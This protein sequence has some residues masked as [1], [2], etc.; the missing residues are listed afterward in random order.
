[1]VSVTVLFVGSSLLASL[2]RAEREI[3]ERYGVAAKIRAHNATLPFAGQQWTSVERDLAA[4]DIVFVI[5]VTDS[6]N[7]LQIAGALDRYRERHRAVVV[8]N[9]LRDLM[10][11]TRMGKLDLTGRSTAAAPGVVRR[12]GAWMASYARGRTKQHNG[13]SPERYLKY[14]AHVP[15]IL[16]II[17][18]RGRLLD[19]KHYLTLFSYFL[20]PTPA[21]VRSMLL[22]AIK[23]YAAV[24][25]RRIKLD[26]PET[27]PVVGIYH[28]D[29]PSVF[30]TFK[31]YRRWYESR[32]ARPRL[33]PN[34]SIGMLLMRTQIVSGACRHYDYLIRAIESEGLPVIP[35]LSTFM[36]NR[37]ACRAFLVNPDDQS[38]R[39][40]QLL[41][42]TGFSFVGGPAM[43]DSKAA[44]QFLKGLNRPF[45][46][47][48]NL[49]AQRIED[50]IENPIGLNPVQTAMQVAIPEI[51]GATDPIVF[52]GAPA[53]GDQPE[54]IEER[55][56]R[57][58]RRLARWDRLRTAPKADIRLAVVL[59]CFPPN[60]GNLGTAADLDVF[61]S[62]F[63][64]LRRLKME[65]YGID[66]PAGPDALREMLLDGSRSA[67]DAPA[68]IAHR[69][70]ADD[71]Y[72]LCPY[73]EEIELEW[74]PAPGRINSRGRDI[75]I[76]GVRLGDAFIG[77]QPTFGY[78]GDPMRL[79]M[80]KGSAPHHGF[81]GFYTFL[82]EVFRADAVIH[83]GTH[84]ALEFMPGKQAGL[85]GR[86]WPDRLIG[87]FPNI[88]VYSVNNPSEGSIA[89]RRSYAEL[90]SYLTPPVENAGLY[91]EL[92]SLKELIAA[93][94]QAAD[95]RQREYL[96][97]AIRE[98]AADLHLEPSSE[99]IDE[100][101]PVP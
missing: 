71:Y 63:D 42:L 51:D 26:P 43:N 48:V 58:A 13:R 91:K 83:F 80:A 65:G 82:R 4:S 20:Q 1:M 70:P 31:A 35:A 8:I 62:L 15:A 12:A 90:I 14:F 67:G 6:E 22:Y 52:G 73:V 40:G 64:I 47:V 66:L 32:P 72:R 61:P 74:G 68:A 69:L 3:N 17:P 36:D 60:R 41:S 97:E 46:S 57:I 11:R 85:S 2:R 55:C 88:Y 19:S 44:V 37:E 76:H 49:E 101:L 28:P 23:H 50:W 29:A 25:G 89:K 79:L 5:H 81:M 98:K 9:C 45:H 92:A 75:M 16:R 18:A 33:D 10:L 24:D 54:P 27:R 96:F 77:V 21:N 78:E 84:G 34:R 53:A 93:Y 95:E 99:G 94:R 38:P 59:Y 86:C 39:V 56:R 100:R 87:D 30:P 7:A